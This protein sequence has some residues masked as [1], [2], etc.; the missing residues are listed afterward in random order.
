MAKANLVLP[1]GTKVSIEGTADEVAVLLGRFS[2]Q[3]ASS[4]PTKPS[5]KKEK[6]FRGQFTY[7][8]ARH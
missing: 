8:L 7:W 5:K 3:E 2:T 1:D 6:E 4:A